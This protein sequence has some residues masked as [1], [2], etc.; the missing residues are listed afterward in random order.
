MAE[1]VGETPAPQ[2]SPS[3][4]HSVVTFYATSSVLVVFSFA[5]LAGRI[6]PRLSNGIKIRLDDWLVI[7]GF[8]RLPHYTTLPIPGTNT[9]LKP[10]FRA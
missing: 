7:A 1:G 4:H 6:V 9:N 2:I 3:A 10:R 8:V 5:A